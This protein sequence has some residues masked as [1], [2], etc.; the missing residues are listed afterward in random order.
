MTPTAIENSIIEYLKTQ[1]KP[2]TYKAL[3][4]N[5]GIHQ[6]I[7]IELLKLQDQG[8]IKGISRDNEFVFYSASTI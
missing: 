1:D 6:D 4:K 5:L 7:Y 2:I 8:K 3:K